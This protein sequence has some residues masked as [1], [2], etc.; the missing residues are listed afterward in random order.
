MP[1]RVLLLVLFFALGL[2]RPAAAED[3]LVRLSFGSGWDAL[4]AIVAIERGFFAQEDIVISSMPIS[5]AMSAMRSVGAGSSDFAAVP[6]RTFLV[7]AAAELPVKAV[8]VNGWSTRMELVVPPGDSATGGIEDLRGKRVAVGSGSDLLP[9]LVRLLNQ[10]KMK[11]GDVQIV[12]MN[13]AQ[14]RSAFKQD[15]A[16]AVFATQHFTGVLTA[17]GSR[18]ALGHQAIVD[19]L[20]TLGTQPLVASNDIINEQPDVVGRVVAAWVKALHYIQQDPEDAANLL[21]I[22]FHRQG[23]SVN[24]AQAK[25]WVAMTR[26]DKYT[27]SEDDVVDAEYNGWGLQAAKILKKAPKLSGYVDNRF[28]E[29]AL[30]TINSN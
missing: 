15:I 27:W 20:G 14:L 18:T 8:S 24:L 4:P 12:E 25:A 3:T 10:A 9:V 26:Y 6:Q 17:E 29:T 21:G 23:V 7:M 22:Y 28:A 11:P 1:V 5:S 16:D 30:R 19:R 2:A 13:S